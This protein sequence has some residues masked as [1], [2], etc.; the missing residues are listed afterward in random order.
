MNHDDIKKTYIPPAASVNAHG[1]L[2]M[3][4]MAPEDIVDACR[5]LHEEYNLPLKTIVALDER[6]EQNTFTILYVFGIPGQNKF[7]APF[8][9]VSEG[10]TFP[11]LLPHIP[12]AQLYE[13][14]IKTFFGIDAAGNPDK[15]PL[16]LHENWPDTIFPLRKD[17]DAHHRPPKAHGPYSFSFVK[18]EG[19]YEIPVGPIHA[20]IIEPGHFRFSVAGEKILLLEAKLGYKHK[21]SEKLFETLPLEDTVR[22]S[23]RISG[24]SSF[25]HSLAF[26][27]A[28]EMLSDTA[29]PD[30]A[31][32]LRVV[33]AELERIA[34][35]SGD[36]GFIL[37]DTGF[38]FG[39]S[40]GSRLREIILRLN[41][42]LV[43][44]RF[45]R[46]VNIIGGV[47]KDIS[48][49]AA[50]QLE[51]DLMKFMIDFNEVIKIAENSG[52]I[53]HRLKDSG[54]VNL[55][56]ATE[57][58]VVGV[59]ARAAGI[60]MDARVDYPYAVY[61]QCTVPIALEHDGDVYSRFRVRVKEVLTSLSIIRGM[62][63]TL[64]GDETLISI[65]GRPLKPDSYAVGIT[66]G[67]RGDIVYVV[68]TDSKGKIARVDVRDPSFL[69]WPAAAFSARG[70]VVPDFPLINKSFNLSYSGNDL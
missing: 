63:K 38:N 55:K 53:L 10:D 51:E 19:I 59:P 31:N 48:A 64:L 56:A 43:G 24:D 70:N 69:N 29:V 16:L 35:H 7:L 44:S 13:R 22:L 12:Q 2:I 65:P 68:A 5:K 4:E 37:M 46:G 6:A 30:R 67:W 15:R 1:N 45:L 26:C 66:E 40:N 61:G 9:R 54:T 21:G 23:E 28:L 57:L 39:G 25:N 41:N 20:G 49:H 11:S 18:G 8:I 17:V 32:M 62:L 3:Y 42:R 52:T 50:S 27:Q 14:K 60:R 58:G 36:I 33:Y 47:S 34:N